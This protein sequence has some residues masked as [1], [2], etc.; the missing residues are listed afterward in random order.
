M[1]G[2]WQIEAFGMWVAFVVIISIVCW[3]VVWGCFTRFAGVIAC[4][5]IV[6][7]CFECSC[8]ERCVVPHRSSHVVFPHVVSSPSCPLVT[9]VTSC[10]PHR[11]ARGRCVS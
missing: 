2:E 10:Q 1:S 3:V 11:A 9:L 5:G 8:L 4:V 7:L 6:L